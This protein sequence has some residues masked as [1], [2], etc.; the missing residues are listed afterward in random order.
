VGRDD[1]IV[2]YL[3]DQAVMMAGTNY[4]DPKKRAR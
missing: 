4:P 3:F 2:A 1:E